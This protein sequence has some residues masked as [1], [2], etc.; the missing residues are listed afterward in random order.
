MFRS[1]L[2]T[3]EGDDDTFHYML[4]DSDFTT[5]IKVKRTNRHMDTSFVRRCNAVITTYEQHGLDV[6]K[7]V[8]LYY[9]YERRHKHSIDLAQQ[10]DVIDVCYPLLQYGKKYYPCVLNRIAMLRYGKRS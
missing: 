4:T 8:A 10:K 2:C 7:N 3:G 5:N 6:P 1:I 9:E